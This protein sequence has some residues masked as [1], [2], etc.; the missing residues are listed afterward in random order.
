[1]VIAS[2]VDR[3]SME[4]QHLDISIAGWKRSLVDATVKRDERQAKKEELD[5]DI[6]A[7]TE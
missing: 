1:V 3:Y 2:S 4:S 6:L 5:V 7:I